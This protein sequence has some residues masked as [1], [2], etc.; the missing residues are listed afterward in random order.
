MRKWRTNSSLAIVMRAGHRAF[1]CPDVTPWGEPSITNDAVLQAKT[2]RN[3]N[4]RGAIKSRLWDILGD[5]LP[6]FWQNV[7]V[8][9]RRFYGGLLHRKGDGIGPR[10]LRCRIPNWIL[11]SKH[12]DNGRNRCILGYLGKFELQCCTIVKFQG[13]NQAAVM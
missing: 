4:P 2:D 9:W 10:W 8:S 3:L 11:K 5:N 13:G 7:S 1:V 12:G 6:G